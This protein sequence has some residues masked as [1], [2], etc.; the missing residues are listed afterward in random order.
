MYGRNILLGPWKRVLWFPTLLWSRTYRIKQSTLLI[1]PAFLE[2][3][4][5]C[6]VFALF[7][8]LHT[9]EDKKR[10]RGKGKIERRIWDIFFCFNLLLPFLLTS[11]SSA[12]LSVIDECQAEDDDYPCSPHATCDN[13][14]GS[15]VCSCKSGY[16]GDGFH[17]T[18]KAKGEVTFRSI[19]FSGACSPF[20][21][22][23]LL[24][25]SVKLHIFIC[26][27]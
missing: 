2:S 3:S 17:C 5:C 1:V 18:S 12:F 19:F 4:G 9:K 26:D 14:S 8:F 7:I 21:L 22:C 6:K 25:A 11:F 24:T 27:W 16:S 13:S 15:F 20:F 23:F 10:G